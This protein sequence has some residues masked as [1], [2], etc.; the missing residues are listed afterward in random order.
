VPNAIA[1]ITPGDGMS[2]MPIIVAGLRALRAVSLASREPAG[3][4]LVDV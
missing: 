1:T 3:R 4:Q 2:A